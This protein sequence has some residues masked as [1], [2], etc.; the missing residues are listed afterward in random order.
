MGRASVDKSA[1]RDFFRQLWRWDQVV[2][3][4]TKV[5]KSSIER[6]P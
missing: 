2:F 6:M 1:S 3:D 5:R 4:T